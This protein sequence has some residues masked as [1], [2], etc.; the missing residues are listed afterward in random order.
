MNNPCVF[1]L[2]GL[3]RWNMNAD[4]PFLNHAVLKVTKRKRK[5]RSKNTSTASFE[6]KGK[7]YF[8]S[9]KSWRFASQPSSYLSGICSIEFPCFLYLE[10]KLSW[11]VIECVSLSLETVSVSASF[12]FL[13]PTHAVSGQLFYI[14]YI[15]MNFKKYA[16]FTQWNEI[17]LSSGGIC[18]YK[19]F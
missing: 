4:L 2:P 7:L 13:G 11:E 3:K 10:R 9:A 16:L 12:K 8:D 19:C 18:I 1:R 15:F 5:K 6:D 14:L 17:A